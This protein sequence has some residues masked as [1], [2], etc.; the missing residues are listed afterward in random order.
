LGA[1]FHR[2][3]RHTDEGLQVMKTLWQD[4]DPHFAGQFYNFKAV[5]FGPKPVQAGGPPI[6]IGGASEAAIRRMA[7]L[8]DGWAADDAPLEQIAAVTAQLR[9]LTAENK[10]TVEITLRRTVDLRPAAAEAGLLTAPT[11]ESGIKVGQWPG[12]STGA[13]TGS[14]T[15][16]KAF[17]QQVTELGVTH[18]ICQFE[19][20][21]QE[22]HLAQ[23]E[24]FAG[25]VIGK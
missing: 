14:L 18:F 3:G 11:N 15:E 23:L 16:I 10:R 24:L 6:W 8:G 2:R 5:L 13:L 9:Q 1:D 19:H 22:E 12:S 21:T 20:S 7:V 17:I 25:E 4:D